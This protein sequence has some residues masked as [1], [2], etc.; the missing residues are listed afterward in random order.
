MTASPLD[1]AQ[2]MLV[3]FQRATK[4]AIEIA[5]AP[6][7]TMAHDYDRPIPSPNCD[8]GLS[9]DMGD[10]DAHS[11]YCTIWDDWEERGDARDGADELNAYEAEIDAH[12]PA[13]FYADEVMTLAGAFWCYTHKQVVRDCPDDCTERQKRIATTRSVANSAL[14]GPDADVRN[15]ALAMHNEFDVLCAYT[16]PDHSMVR[17]VCGVCRPVRDIC[18]Q[19]IEE[20]FPPTFSAATV[21]GEGPEPCDPSDGSGVGRTGFPAAVTPEPAAGDWTQQIANILSEHLPRDRGLGIHCRHYVDRRGTLAAVNP[22]AVTHQTFDDWPEWRLH[23]AE[24]INEQLKSPAP[25][26]K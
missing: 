7:P 14:R 16:D 17:E 2:A 25:H 9:D 6:L 21:V 5:C 26:N 19:M 3:G 24:A 10:L 4:R 13:D 20:R 8:C 11:S 22:T 1:R 23:V 12:G 18:E 15:P